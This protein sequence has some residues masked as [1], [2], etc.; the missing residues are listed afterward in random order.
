MRRKYATLYRKGTPTGDPNCPEE[1]KLAKITI[2]WAIGNGA[3]IGDC[4]EEFNLEDASFT[5]TKPESL[6]LL[7]CC[8]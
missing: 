4:E 2:K 7:R 8:R 5:T 3:A 1:V 6:L